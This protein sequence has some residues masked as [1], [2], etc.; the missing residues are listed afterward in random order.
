ML[1]LFLHSFVQNHFQLFNCTLWNLKS[2]LSHIYSTWLLFS[3]KTLFLLWSMAVFSS[4]VILCI[5]T[6]PM[7]LLLCVFIAFALLFVLWNTL[8]NVL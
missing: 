7:F 2:K 5:I 1:L 4:P 6:T 8:G 3:S